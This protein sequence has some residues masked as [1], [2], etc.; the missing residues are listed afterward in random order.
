MKIN[1]TTPVQQTRK[2]EIELT[3]FELNI[4][5]NFLQRNFYDTRNGDE[6]R[7]IHTLIQG[8][9]KVRDGK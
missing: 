1:D 2:M 5:E 6:N 9:K 8:I 3:V 7:A 4:L